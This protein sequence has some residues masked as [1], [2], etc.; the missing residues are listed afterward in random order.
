MKR[1]VACRKVS[2]ALRSTL[3][4]ML[5]LIFQIGKDSYAIGVD[6][7]IEVLP[8]V[9]HKQ[10]PRAPAGLTGLFNYHGALVPLIDLTEL[11]LGRSSDSKMSTRIIVTNYVDEVGKKHVIGLMAEQVMETMRREPTDF[12]DSG[13][14]V[15]DSLY[16]GPVTTD[17]GR[18]IQQIEVDSLFPA[19]LRDQLF[20]EQ[21]GSHQ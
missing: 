12:V 21:V 14:S 2:P 17:N 9:R 19:S 10:I 3:D 4:A 20:R 15:T 5:F 7:V 6:R 8:L 16:L 11:A 1:P 13:M 18:I